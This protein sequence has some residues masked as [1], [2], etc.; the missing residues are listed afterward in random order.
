MTAETYIKAQLAAL[1]H[2]EAAH[3]GGV[4]NMLAVAFVMRNRQRAGWFGGDWMEI[5]H[6]AYKVAA[7]IYPPSAP[8]LRDLSFRSFLQQVDDIYTGMA[9]DAMTEG[10][11]YYCELHRIERAWFHENILQHGQHERVAN[12]GQV[13]FF[14]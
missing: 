11:L 1:A 10:A 13:A 14:K 4:N 7:A 6:N 9:Q 8:N 2:R 3:M 12:V 5:I